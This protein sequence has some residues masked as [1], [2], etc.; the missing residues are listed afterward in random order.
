MVSDIRILLTT[1]LDDLTIK[2]LHRFGTSISKSL[3]TGFT[4]T[5]DQIKVSSLL[6]QKP[7]FEI[8]AAYPLGP[9]G[10]I[11]EMLAGKL[12]PVN[13]K[14]YDFFVRFHATCTREQKDAIILQLLDSPYIVSVKDGRI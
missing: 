5:D 3:R 7:I 12:D 13:E 9:D 8:T 14:S 1:D 6:N 2:N 4:P 10:T 11:E